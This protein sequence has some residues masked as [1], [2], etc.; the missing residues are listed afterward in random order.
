MNTY[1]QRAVFP[2]IKISKI[3]RMRQIFKLTTGLLF[4]VVALAAC[5]KDNRDIAESPV[6]SENPVIEGRGYGHNDN[7]HVYTLSN[8]ADGNKVIDYRRSANG[9]LVFENSYATGGN[10]T[11]GGLGNQGAVILAGED[12][13]LAVNAG[14]NTIS[15]FRIR[16]NGLQLRSTVQSG[17]MRPV[18]ITEHEGLVYVLN[19]GGNGNIS[20][21]RLLPNNRLEP[22]PNSTRPLSVA[23]PTGPAQISFVRRGQVLVITEKATNTI[24]TYT[25]NYWGVPGVKH[26]LTSSSP[27]PFGFATGRLGNIFVSEAVGGAPGASVLS[28]YRIHSDGN[29]SLVNGSVGAGQSAACWVVITDNGRYAYTTNTA[30]NNISTFGVNVFNGNLNV[31]QAISATTEADPIDAALSSRSKYLYVLNGAA[32]SIDVFEVGFNGSL[33]PV[34]TVPGLPMGAN[35]LAAR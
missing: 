9:T 27:T 33:S 30:S 24:T 1:T 4:M 11:G 15:S 31:S 6:E 22:I 32:K 28:S 18:S 35:G 29:I 21:F 2:A 20:G 13:L 12:V 23:A 14:S 34:Q 17:G 25:V 10:G 5:R 7:G 8:A 26:T 16:P 19:A 3:K